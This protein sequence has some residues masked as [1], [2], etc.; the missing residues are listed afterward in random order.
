M[1]IYLNVIIDYSN[2]TYTPIFG[3][4]ESLE[5]SVPRTSVSVLICLKCKWTIISGIIICPFTFNNVLYEAS[6]RGGC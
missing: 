6:G 4:G 5:T 3:N 2:V 1:H